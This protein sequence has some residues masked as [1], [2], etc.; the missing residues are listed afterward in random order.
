MSSNKYDS[1]TSNGFAMGQRLIQRASAATRIA[2]LLI[3]FCATGTL[4]AAEIHWKNGVSG[5]WNVGTNWVGDVVPGSSDTAVIDPAGTYTVT[6]DVS[7]GVSGFRLA[8]TS[9][10]F[11]TSTNTITVN[12]IA[13]L[14]AGTI[15]IVSG[16]SFTVPGSR[17]FQFNGGSLIGSPLLTDATL[18]FGSEAGQTGT[19]R[20]QGGSAI[21]T[22]DISLNAIVDFKPTFAGNHLLDW[23]SGRTVNG[24]LNMDST[25]AGGNTNLRVTTLDSVTNNGEI[26]LNQGSGGIR[27]IEAQLVNNGILEQTSTNASNTLGKSGATHFNNGDITLL[28]GTTLTVLGTAFHEAGT[29]ISGGGTLTLNGVQF[30]GVGT[31]G[32][33]VVLTNSAVLNP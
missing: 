12:G 5:N 14:N 26:Y 22:G 30:F 4:H 27:Q 2:V 10:T 31:M 21:I 6:L 25:A 17:T 19:V 33:N 15:E 23:N 3:S 16:G 28:G 1:S 20:V 32:V 7:P 8:S 13:T 29:T 9:A 24:T 18:A 11:S